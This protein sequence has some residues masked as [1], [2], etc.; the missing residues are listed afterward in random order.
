MSNVFTGQVQGIS[1]IATGT[2]AAFC[3]AI[4]GGDFAID[5]NNTIFN[6]IGGQV[7]ARKGANAITLS[8]TCGGVDKADLALWFPVTAVVQ[9]ATFPDFLIEVDDGTNGQEWVLTGGQ[10]SSAKVSCAG[11]LGSE[12][13]YTLGMSFKLATE[14][15][16]GTKVPVYN[17]LIG[18]TNN[19][20]GVTYGGAAAGTLS[21]D[22]S[23]D[24]GAEFHNPMDAKTAGVQHVVDGVYITKNDVKFSAV[25]SNVLKGTAMDVDT[26]T[27]EA[28]VIAMLNGTAGQNITATLSNMVP[29]AWGMPVEAQGRIGF[30]HEWIPGPGTA[31]NRV[32]FT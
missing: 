14:Q 32:V 26:W 6:G 5:P 18:H 7:V 28:V 24:L 4:S 15:A 8:F 9:V 31:F 30:K 12:V 11:G 22:L 16:V 17:S 27:P 19:N 23:N 21:F 29:G 1:K 25:L 10:P 13:Q 2:P 20:I 3:R